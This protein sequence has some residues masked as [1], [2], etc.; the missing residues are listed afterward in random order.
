ML[1]E[2]RAVGTYV[3]FQTPKGKIFENISD[4]AGYGEY[5]TEITS[6]IEN[7]IDFYRDI[8][9]QSWDLVTT[10]WLDPKVHQ[11]LLQQVTGG[12]KVH[13]SKLVWWDGTEDEYAHHHLQIF[14]MEGK[15]CW[16]KILTKF[17]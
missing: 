7:P 4:G 5:H 13:D 3:V 14:L 9:E 15:L 10:I 6:N 8:N 12:R 1:D 16:M 11:K 2:Y 17:I